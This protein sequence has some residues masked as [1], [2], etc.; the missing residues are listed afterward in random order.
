MS[1]SKEPK[2]E[3]L[4]LR[5]AYQDVTEKG[6]AIRAAAR[7]HGLPESTF[8]WRLANNKSDDVKRGGPAFFLKEP[9]KKRWQIIAFQWLILEMV[10]SGG[11]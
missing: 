8:R 10:S 1:K 7:S 11:K 4:T 9:G 5:K 6:M 2:Y 3:Y